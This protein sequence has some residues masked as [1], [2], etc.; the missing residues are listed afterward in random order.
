[1]RDPKT[2]D[3][4]TNQKSFQTTSLIMLLLIIKKIYLYS[5]IFDLEI[6]LANQ[7]VLYKKNHPCININC[8]TSLDSFCP[9]ENI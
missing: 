1:M 2:I 6:Y 3:E 7:I 4:K 9:V 5:F 8:Q